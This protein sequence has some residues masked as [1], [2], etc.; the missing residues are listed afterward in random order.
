MKIKEIDE[1][2]QKLREETQEKYF[3]EE[4][5]TSSEKTIWK[6]RFEYSII[7][8]SYE[9]YIFDLEKEKYIVVPHYFERDLEKDFEEFLKTYLEENNLI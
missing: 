5:Y 4:E 3:S 8:G 7:D 6:Y 9:F 1:I 2:M